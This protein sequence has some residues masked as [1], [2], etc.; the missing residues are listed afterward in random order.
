MVRSDG[1]R[2]DGL[3]L[4]TWQAGRCATW[5]VTIIDLVADSFVGISA[6]CTGA[7]TEVAANRKDAKYIE[8]SQSHLIFPVA[9]ETIGPINQTGSDFLSLIGHRLSIAGI[10]LLF[11]SVCQ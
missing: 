1:K 8:I 5:D 10:V 11:F 9:F 7:A 2:P 3:T 4:V 6:A